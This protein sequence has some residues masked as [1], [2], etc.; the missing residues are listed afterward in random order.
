MSMEMQ[1]ETGSKHMEAYNKEHVKPQSNVG[2]ISDDTFKNTNMS[3]TNM[4]NNNAHAT[5]G[6]GGS[7]SSVEIISFVK[8]KCSGACTNNETEH[9]PSSTVK[10]SM[11][12]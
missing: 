3:V 1:I 8:K 9:G 12:Q 4:A 7:A 11:D 6:S 10:R 2:G 5:S